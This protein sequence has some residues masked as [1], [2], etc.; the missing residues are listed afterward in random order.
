MK[1][2]A[3]QTASQFAGKTSRLSG[4]TVSLDGQNLCFKIPHYEDSKET[5]LI[6]KDC[7][8]HSFD[9]SKLLELSED[10]GY[11]LISGEQE[12]N[13]AFSAEQVIL[14]TYQSKSI[15]LQYKSDKL[16]LAWL[17]TPHK[18]CSLEDATLLLYDDGQ[19][20]LS[21]LTIN[22]TVEDLRYRAFPVIGIDGP[23]TVSPGDSVS[24]SVTQA[25]PGA[26]IYLQT[27]AGVLNKSRLSSSGT[28]QITAQGLD[29][30]D[31]IKI[32]AGY[33]HWTGDAEHIITVQ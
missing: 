8:T 11:I 16:R 7:P 15:P 3:Y 22:E 30:G 27:T 25:I 1:I 19:I 2:V 31:Q 21:S 23:S 17:I 9:L 24:L 32:K 13:P 28:V 20:D 26:V 10:H 12:S 33:R 4:C 14:T 29:S 5:N 6:V 18:G